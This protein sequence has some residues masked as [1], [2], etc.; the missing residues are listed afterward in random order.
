MSVT[1]IELAARR[2]VLLDGALGTELMARGL[3]QGACPEAW[4]VERPEV[5]REIHAAYFAAGSDAVSTNSFG[6][7]RV[8]LGGHGLGA[9]TAELNAAA[10]RL[11]RAEAPA[12]KFVA[13]SMGPTGKFLKPQGEFTEE[14]FEAAYAEQAAALAEG[15]ADVLLIE[16][17]YDLREA[18]CALRGA[19]RATS[20]PVLATMTYNAVPRGYFTLM[21]DP[22]ARCLQELGREGAAAVG[23][24]CTLNSEQMAGLVAVMR[25]ETVLPL[26]AQANA[27]KPVL[28]PGG[29]VTYSQGLEDYVRFVPEIV[30]GGANIVGGCCGTSPAYIKAMAESLF[31]SRT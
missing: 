6:G 16:T 26:I 15:G 31:R 8:K 22:V 14:E 23:A 3:P 17:Q 20:L 19:R 13:G 24:N 4:N 12:G 7:S 2:T 1:L 11:A 18:L 21:G 28:G 27:G 10:A 9:R 25:S 30:R 5:V 29:A